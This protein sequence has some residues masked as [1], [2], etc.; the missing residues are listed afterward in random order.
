MSLRAK[1]RPPSNTDGWKPRL[2]RARLLVALRTFITV[3]VVTLLLWIWADLERESH[4][5][6]TVAVKV[7]APSGTDLRVVSPAEPVNVSVRLVGS[8]E[9]LSEF[10]RRLH[11]RDATGQKTIY[12]V[13]TGAGWEPGG[14]YSINVPEALRKWDQ[15][16]GLSP[17]DATPQA[18]PVKLDRWVRKEV[19]VELWTTDNAAVRDVAVVPDK[20]RVR[21]PSSRQ[22]ELGPVPVIRTQEL[23]LDAYAPGQEVHNRLV[24]LA[25]NI[26]GVPAVPVDANEVSVSFRM[27]SRTEAKDFTANVEVLASP[28]LV[29]RMSR[30]GL[31]LER[32]DSSPLGEW[33]LTLRVRGS[34]DAIQHAATDPTSIRAF[35]RIT[36]SDFLQ[37][38]TF[39][40]RPVTVV[41]PAGLELESPISPTVSF[42]FVPQ[43]PGAPSTGQPPIPG[44][45]AP[46]PITSTPMTAPI[47]SRPNGG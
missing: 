7:V 12:E 17:S 47:T 15:I 16:R 24:A 9:R 10:L 44:P 1:I 19:K 39:P 25:N 11:E 27:G 29:E 32:Q 38:A 42:R 8:R 26:N 14:D 36:E 22:G 31:M 37:T 3:G 43:R 28:E 2:G 4:E 34:R 41:L 35:V 6:V 33:H 5:D 23:K 40:A 46:P 30:E 21:V 20:M 45:I 18:I 13:Q